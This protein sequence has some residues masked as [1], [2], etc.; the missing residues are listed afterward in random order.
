MKGGNVL[1]TSDTVLIVDAAIA[2][3][4]ALP[5]YDSNMKTDLITEI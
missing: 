4:L 3:L 1:L 2:V 5:W